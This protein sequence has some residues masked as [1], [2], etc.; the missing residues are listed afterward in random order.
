MA[1]AGVTV[2]VRVTGCPAAAGFGV[3]DRLAAVGFVVRFVAGLI[4]SVTVADV[5]ALLPE[6][7]L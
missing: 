3:A 6:S 7:P 4:A 5:L 1:L 2:A